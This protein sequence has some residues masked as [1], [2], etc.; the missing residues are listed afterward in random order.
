MSNLMSFQN[1]QKLIFFI[2]GILSFIL[3]FHVFFSN[4]IEFIIKV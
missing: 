4:Y 2:F 3:I 1:Q